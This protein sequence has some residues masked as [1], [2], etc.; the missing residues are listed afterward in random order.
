MSISQSLF[1]GVILHY[2]T[3]TSYY[4]LK[5]IIQMTSS[6]YNTI[7]VEEESNRV[8]KMSMSQSIFLGFTLHY[9][10]LT[11]YYILKDIIQMTSTYSTIDVEE[12]NNKMRKC[13][14]HNQYS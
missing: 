7:D 6:N 4:I 1:L 10:I 13:Q 5:D 3:L 11:N 12:E 14:C 9:R 2:I 8:K